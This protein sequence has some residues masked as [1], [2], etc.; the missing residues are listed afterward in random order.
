M[1]D[2][3]SLEE[4]EE[5]IVIQKPKRQLTDKQKEATALNLAKGRAVRD[6]KREIKKEESLAKKEQDKA[7]IEEIVAKKAVKLATA[8]AK[9]ESKL[10]QLMG[11]S[12]SEEDVDIEE[13]VFKRPKKKKIIYREESDSEE[14]VAI[15]KRRPEVPAPAPAPTVVPKRVPTIMF[16]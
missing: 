13:R 2:L 4:I 3:E 6:A 5:K 8:R 15:K 1:E 12:L 11:E 16:Y 14:E 7:R 9:K 10:K